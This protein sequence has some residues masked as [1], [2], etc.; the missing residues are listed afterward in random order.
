MSNLSDL[1]NFEI[2]PYFKAL[3]AVMQAD[4]VIDDSEKEF[5]SNQA[6][7]LNVNIEQL[8]DNNIVLS[9]IDLMNLSSTTKKCIIRDCISLAYA[10][11]HYAQEEKDKIN[12]IAALAGVDKNDVEKI[13]KWLIKY[14]NVLEEGAALLA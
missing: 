12:E 1:K 8:I 2:E 11:D 6:K 3:I 10:D 4:G 13:E 9:D 7:I 5:I 14:W